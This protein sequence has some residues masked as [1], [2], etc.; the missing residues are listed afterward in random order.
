MTRKLTDE[1]QFTFEFHDIPTPDERKKMSAEGLAIVLSKFDGRKA[2]HILIEHE[3]QLR[4]AK[5]QSG[6]TWKAAAI[7]AIAGLIFAILGPVLTAY[8][9]GQQTGNQEGGRRDG[10]EKSKQDVQ[11]QAPAIIQPVAL[12]KVIQPASSPPPTVS[13]PAASQATGNPKR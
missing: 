1:E 7:G 12:A 2:A 13:R 10:N 6:A 8:I 4:L 3:L 5:E 9:Q 11:P